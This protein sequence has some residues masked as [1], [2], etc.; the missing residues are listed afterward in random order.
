[1]EF[2][3]FYLD[4]AGTQKELDVILADWKKAADNMDGVKYVAHWIPHS[5]KWHHAV[6]YEADSYAKVRK[7]WRSIGTKRDY[8]KLTHGAMELFVEPNEM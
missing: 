1:M 4:W 3:I 7:S 8:S 2:I 6:F 5:T